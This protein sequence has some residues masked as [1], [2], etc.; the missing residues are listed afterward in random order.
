MIPQSPQITTT[1][2]ATTMTADLVEA[3]MEGRVMLLYLF[4]PFLPACCCLQRCFIESQ[5][6]LRGGETKVQQ[7]WVLPK[8][9]KPVIAE[10][11]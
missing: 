10:L 9:I 2:T 8:I 7:L 11:G 1:T 4:G 6:I 5:A 3:R